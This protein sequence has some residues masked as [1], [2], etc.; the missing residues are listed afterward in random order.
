MTFRSLT[1]GKGS[2]VMEFDS[3]RPCEEGFLE[4][5]PRRGVDP[6]DRAKWIL[7]CRSA[8]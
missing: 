7:S 8:Y 2:Y 3:Y 1:S 6:L 4:T 5:L